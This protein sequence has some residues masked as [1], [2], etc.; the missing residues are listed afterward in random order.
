LDNPSILLDA[1]QL[2]QKGGTGIRSYTDTL[3]RCLQSLGARVNLLFGTDSHLR[4]GDPH[5]ALADQIFCHRPPPRRLAH[6]VSVALRSRMG[7]KTTVEVLEVPLGEV[8]LTYLEP[9]LPPFHRIFNA[10]AV[11]D[12]S[13]AAS[14]WGPRMTTVVPPQEFAAHHWT[15][16]VP[17]KSSRGP[18]LYT[19]HDLVPIQFP[20]LVI[21]RPGE[22]ARLHTAIARAAD[23]IITVSETSKAKIL[24][25]LKVPSERVTVTYQPAP[26]PKLL[27]QEDA[28]WLVSTLYNATPKSYALYLGAVEPKKNLRRLIE[29]F[30]MARLDIPLLMAGPLGWLYDEENALFALI[31]R[32]F[33]SEV[34]A[35]M[36]GATPLKE[37]TRVLGSG[38][39]TGFSARDLPVRHLGYLPRRHVTALLQCAKFF[40]FPSIYEGFGL[41]ALE[42]MQ[43]NVPVLTSRTGSLCEVV[44]EAALLI[45]PLDIDDIV[46][47]IRQLDADSDLRIELAQRGP[48]QAAKFS[49][50]AYVQ[51]LR[52][53]YAKV[54]VFFPKS[55]SPEVEHGTEHLYHS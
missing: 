15:G 44:G 52:N 3:A 42:A 54:G 34:S 27:P 20:Y 46:R 11:F 25:I 30:L 13:R 18:N 22:S 39:R 6:L 10:E 2:L 49:E 33:G 12:R 28:E 38:A 35:D 17:I 43:V 23:G 14:L 31:N 24:E 4:K 29:A 53:A 21:D 48:V 55:R 40:V 26:T 9:P 51:R 36:L 50:D 32:R 45:D 37:P 41:P 47:G 1:T 16:P 8:D 19:I 5:F 7:L